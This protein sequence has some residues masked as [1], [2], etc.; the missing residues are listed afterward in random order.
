MWPSAP[1]CSS[2]KA[3]SGTRPAP[4]G[5]Q[6]VRTKSKLQPEPALRGKAGAPGG[7][8][9]DDADL[10]KAAGSLSVRGGSA[11]GPPGPPPAP[12]G[13]SWDGEGPCGMSELDLAAWEAGAGEA[14]AEVQPSAAEPV[15][16]RVG[17]P[18]S[19]GSLAA[20]SRAESLRESAE[21]RTV[22]EAAAAAVELEAD[23]QPSADGWESLASELR[24]GKV[25]GL[26][27]RAWA[28]S[29]CWRTSSSR[30]C[31]PACS[32]PVPCAPGHRC[33]PAP[34]SCPW[35]MRGRRLTWIHSLVTPDSPCLR[36]MT[37]GPWLTPTPH[38][39]CGTQLPSLRATLHPRPRYRPVLY[40]AG[41]ESARPCLLPRRH[42]WTASTQRRSPP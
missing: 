5:P 15:D 18:E 4:A 11:T 17:E 12:G 6:E 19:P 14:A 39:W 33:L 29:A 28:H 25:G 38:C 32:N 9:D 2:E 20:G 41:D 1:A 37:C 7:A 22:D 8:G 10:I 40:L 24:A 3:T 26:P 36:G 16:A 31:A 27:E 30:R 23:T 34:R 21:E 42:T 35:L 13:L